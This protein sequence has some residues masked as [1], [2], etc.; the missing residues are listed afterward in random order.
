MFSVSEN[1]VR[2]KQFASQHPIPSVNRT[3]H[4]VETLTDDG[5][6]FLIHRLREKESTGA[7]PRRSW[8][9]WRR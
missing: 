1:L 5:S 8:K 4:P 7:L 6:L 3:H 2:E 9:F